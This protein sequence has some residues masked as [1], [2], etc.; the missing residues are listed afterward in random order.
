M[1]GRFILTMLAK[2]LAWPYS[3]ILY[4]VAFPIRKWIRKQQRGPSAARWATWPLW[5]VLDDEEDFGEHWWLKA[6]GLER[7]FVTSWK[8]AWLRNNSWNLNNWLAKSV[9]PYS[10]KEIMIKGWTTNPEKQTPFEHHRFKWEILE[11][12]G[13]IVDGWDVNDGDR[14]SERYTSL[15]TAWMIYTHPGTGLYFRGSKATLWR[16]WLIN[17]KIGW[18]KRGHALIDLK[19]KRNRGY[20]DHWKN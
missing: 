7:N 15:G 19:I 6:H 20:M 8:W 17:Y 5:I 2:A 18:N 14:L 3:L 11:D 4:P 16:G 9:N 10:G 12:D 1:W 13:H